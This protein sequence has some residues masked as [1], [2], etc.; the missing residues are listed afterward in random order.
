MTEFGQCA[1]LWIIIGIVK[2]QSYSLYV[3]LI[4]TVFECSVFAHTWCGISRPVFV[5]KEVAL[6]LE[7]HFFS[8]IYWFVCFCRELSRNL[9]CCNKFLFSKVFP[10][11][12]IWDGYCFLNLYCVFGSD[13]YFRCLTVV[14]LICLSA[15]GELFCHLAVTITKTHRPPQKNA[16]TKLGQPYSEF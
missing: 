12:H 13:C 4:R 5:S 15:H 11:A 10:F 2:K 3:M 14:S 7:M 6:H 9:K 1:N 8:V 16:F